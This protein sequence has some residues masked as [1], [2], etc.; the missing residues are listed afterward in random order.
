MKTFV[1]DISNRSFSMA[2]AVQTAIQVLLVLLSPGTF[3][4]HEGLK[5]A[6]Y[7]TSLIFRFIFFLEFYAMLVAIVP[8]FDKANYMNMNTVYMI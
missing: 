7:C 4:A 1:D 8:D 2:M 3:L 5:G 6:G